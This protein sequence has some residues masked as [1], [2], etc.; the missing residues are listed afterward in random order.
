MV[1]TLPI[2][3]ER[4]TVINKLIKTITKQFYVTYETLSVD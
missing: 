4:V 1:F 3:I 2:P